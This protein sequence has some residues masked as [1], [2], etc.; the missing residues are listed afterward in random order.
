MVCPEFQLD[1]SDAMAPPQTLQDILDMRS[2]RLTALTTALQQDTLAIRG[3]MDS[4]HKVANVYKQSLKTAAELPALLEKLA[5]RLH[6]GADREAA[7]VLAEQQRV[8][9]A[10]EAE[11]QRAHDSAMKDKAEQAL[12]EQR[13]A[14]RAHKQEFEMDND[15]DFIEMVENGATKIHETMEVLTTRR[16]QIEEGLYGQVGAGFS[17]LIKRNPSASTGVEQAKIPITTLMLVG[18]A[19]GSNTYFT[20][21][22]FSND[23]ASTSITLASVQTSA[24]SRPFILS[25]GSVSKV[26][27]SVRS[28]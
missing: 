24:S 25:A 4:A 15:K 27:Q 9:D 28:N 23:V 6:A 19:T 12:R 18:S 2:S 22:A 26:P 11:K 7:R 1:T 16:F 13:A 14:K 20:V 10:A 8:Q 17:N 3:N 21:N 5:E